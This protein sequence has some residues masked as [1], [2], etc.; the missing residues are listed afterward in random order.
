MEPRKR[1]TNGDKAVAFY[2]IHLF[3]EKEAVLYSLNMHLL[4]IITSRYLEGAH[5]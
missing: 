4:Y 2:E 1:R 3:N 5:Q